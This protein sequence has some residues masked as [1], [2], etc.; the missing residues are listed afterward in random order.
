VSKS[1]KVNERTIASPPFGEL[2]F[3]RLPLWTWA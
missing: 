3:D 2:S 1:Q